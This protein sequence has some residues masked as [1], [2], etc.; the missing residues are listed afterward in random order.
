[1][2][3]AESSLTQPV[4]ESSLALD[5]CI[6]L[7][8]R[9]PVTPA[10]TDKELS[11]FG[12]ALLSLELAGFCKHDLIDL[13]ARCLIR[14]ARN[15]LAPVARIIEPPSNLEQVMS[16]VAP[17]VSHRI[18]VWYE[19]GAYRVVANDCVF[20]NIG[21]REQAPAMDRRALD[22]TRRVQVAVRC[23]TARGQ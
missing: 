16:V 9:P 14:D 3:R 21:T 17:L 20:R 7:L 11:A 13:A 4:L 22:F 19:L 5:T 10:V 12:H 15:G 8:K 1:M 6:I 2:A 23:P 18:G